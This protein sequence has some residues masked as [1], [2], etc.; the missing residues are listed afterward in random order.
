MELNE[1]VFEDIYIITLSKIKSNTMIAL[2]E[3]VR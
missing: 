1:I 2:K 3:G